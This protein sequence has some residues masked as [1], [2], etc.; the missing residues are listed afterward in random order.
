MP[1]RAPP[2]TNN[3]STQRHTI[4]CWEQCTIR[5]EEAKTGIQDYSVTATSGKERTPVAQR[6]LPASYI[7]LYLINQGRLELYLD[8][9]FKIAEIREQ[10]TLVTQFW[11]RCND[12]ST[13]LLHHRWRTPYIIRS[14]S[15][16]LRKGMSKQQ[17]TESS[18]RTYRPTIFIDFFWILGLYL[19][20]LFFF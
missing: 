13:R 16:L 1:T 14:I 12:N 20:C 3:P 9:A 2:F 5:Y 19:F 17:H 7:Q 8:L 4:R 15:L 6:Q 11:L 10:K 18:Y